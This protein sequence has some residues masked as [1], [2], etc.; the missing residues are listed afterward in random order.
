MSASPTSESPAPGPGTPAPASVPTTA[1]APPGGAGLAADLIAGAAIAGLLLPEA[2]AYSSIANLPPATGVVALFAGLILYGLFGSSRFAVV[3]ATSSS[4]AVL[5]AAIASFAPG[6]LGDRLALAA[7]LT[8]LTGLFFV[9]ASVLRLGSV[10][11]FIGKPVLRGFTF[12]LAFVIM[13]KQLPPILGV[14]PAHSDVA[15]LLWDLWSLRTQWNG[16]GAATALAALAILAATARLPRIPGAVIVIALGIIAM[17]GLG[18]EG[19]GVA[20]AGA[21]SLAGV[22]LHVPA[23]DHTEWLRLGELALAMVLILFAESSGSIRTFALKHGDRCSPNR[24]LFALGLSNLASGLAGGL[25]AG[26]GFSATAANEAAGARSRWAGV[27]AAGVA[28]FA[29]AELLPWIA[30]TPEPVIAAIVIH[31]VAPSLNPKRF[32]P[33]LRFRRDR[34][35]AFAAI[36]AVLALGVLDGLLAAVAIS[37]ALLMRQ[38]AYS[39]IAEL[40]RLDGGHDFVDRKLH[41]DARPVAGVLVLRPE[42]RVFFANADRIFDQC[43][44]LARAATPQTALVLSLE[45]TPDLDG[46]T[47]EALG[48]LARDLAGQG[49]PLYIARLKDAAL[50]VVTRA[51]LP[52]LPAARASFFS[53]D[54]AVCAAL[55]TAPAPSQDGAHDFVAAAAP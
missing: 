2:V 50:E 41:P 42:E 21:I 37:L 22:G 20:A 11:D 10:S 35:T 30:R 13:A 15:R 19:R 26:A 6:T 45:E 53:V 1:P 16:V 32:A 54:D 39:G 33:Y 31:A 36:V 40:G 25:P 44:R 51:A 47:I 12:G 28:A 18:L 14:H 17:N 5:A 52:E 34:L 23:L 8:A 24:D 43:A 46:S 4:A 27:A 9:A 29:V 3:S 48:N 7:G 49:R 38:L 55:N